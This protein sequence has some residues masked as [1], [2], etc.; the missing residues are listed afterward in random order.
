MGSCLKK[1]KKKKKPQKAFY[2]SS[3]KEDRKLFSA[4]HVVAAWHSAGA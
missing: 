1:K 2:N 4:K 3:E